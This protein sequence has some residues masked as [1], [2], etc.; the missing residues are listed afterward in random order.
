MLTN[1]CNLPEPIYNFLKSDY[2]PKEKQYSVTTI[3]NPTRQIILKRRYNSAIDQDCSDLI[4]AMLGTAFHLVLE[5]SK[6]GDNQLQEEYL[7]QEL[8]CLDDR[9][10][11]YY[12]SGKADLLDIK[13]KKIIDYKTTSSFKFIK[14]DFEDYRLQL[15]IYAWLFKKIG[16]EVNKGEI[17]AI[18]R[19]WQRSKAKFDKSYPQLQVQTI[20][21]EFT[22]KDFEDI[23]IYIKNRFLE[24]K[25]YEDKPDE[26]LPDCT[27]EERWA[28]P[29]IYAIKKFGNKRAIKLYENKKEAITHLKKLNADFG[30]IYEIEV[31][32]SCDG[33]C[34]NYCSCNA[35]CSYYKEKYLN[36]GEK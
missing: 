10:K 27:M 8:S 28:S 18:L 6:A 21:F 12:L 17:V 15:L 32:E 24:I 34:E 20:T 4:W 26:E 16:Y 22:D 30:D 9:L 25:A 14:K 13:Q 29:T 19:D 11:G 36:K 3:L 31:R 23:E 5:N 7:K 1:K 2:Q 33:R 35:F